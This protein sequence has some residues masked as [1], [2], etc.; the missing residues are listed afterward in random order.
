[1]HGGI[2]GHASPVTQA[3]WWLCIWG[4]VFLP[5]SL[6][7]EDLRI[8]NTQWNG[9]SEL[10]A[11]A[12]TEGGT[13]HAEWVDVTRL[14]GDEALLVMHPVIP[15]PVN[16]LAKFMRRGGRVAIADDYGSGSRFF[17][18][19]GMGLHAPK[20]G[21]PSVLRHNQQLPIAT[22]IVGHALADGVD[23]LVTNH[24]QVLFHPTLTPI[25]GLAHDRAAVVLSGAVGNGRLVA[26][27]DGSVFI[28]NML[29]FRGNRAFARNLVRFLH[30]S[31]RSGTL[32]IADSETRWQQSA[33]ALQRPISEVS[34]AL[35]R[36]SHVQL[37]RL[38]VTM[39][40]TLLAGL[41]LSM[42]VTSLPKRSAYA[43][44]AY[45][46]S[47]E[48]AAG[49]AGRVSHYADG[50]RSMLLP[51]GSLRRELEQRAVERARLSSASSRA[52]VRK[53]LGD[54]GATTLAS[55]YEELL[56]EIDRLQDTNAPVSTRRFSELVASGRRILADLD[57]L[58]PLHHERHE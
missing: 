4:L 27:S 9:L 12:A 15:L 17:S 47:V 19:F 57:A 26:I 13:E 6:F 29:Q 49:M 34:N 18:T 45:L 44:R 58:P 35:D 31:G 30:G 3:V 22:P 56:A 8:R 23:A 33:R 21:A 55:E 46:Q 10:F 14:T 52:D 24:P 20:P 53:A 50:D 28:N 11:L 7:A 36:L 37:P 16:D 43:R 41:L 25:F 48:C 2:S 40:S 38:A 54:L 5:S 51:L 32:L 42:V 1:M 39:F